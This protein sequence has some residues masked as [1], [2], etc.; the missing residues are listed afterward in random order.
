MYQKQPLVFYD[1]DQPQSGPKVTRMLSKTT[2]SILRSLFFHVYDIN[3]DDA[4]V[5]PMDNYYGKINGIN[6]E[7]QHSWGCPVYR[8]TWS[9]YHVQKTTTGSRRLLSA[10][11]Y[12]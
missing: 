7:K 8:K 11:H 5:I 9:N 2:V 4:G 1:C 10:V 6:L 3:M 12:F